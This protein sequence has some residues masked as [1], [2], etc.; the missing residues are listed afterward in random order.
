MDLQP[1]KRSKEL[2]LIGEKHI[3]HIVLI[4]RVQFKR[5]WMITM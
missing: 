2:L 5:N 1:I 3:K 4:L